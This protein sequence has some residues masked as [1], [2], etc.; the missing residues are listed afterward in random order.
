MHS[1]DMVG[2]HVGVHT[3]EHYCYMQIIYYNDDSSAAGEL[4]NALADQQSSPVY[5][6]N[7]GNVQVTGVTQA[8]VPIATPS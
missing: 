1:I 7:F 3:S 8:N 6:P 2:C 4:K 5:I